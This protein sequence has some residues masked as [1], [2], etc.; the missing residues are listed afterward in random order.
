MAAGPYLRSF[1][2]IFVLVFVVTTAV[3]FL[4]SLIVHGSGQAEWGSAIRMG[5]ILGIILP[6][7]RKFES[8]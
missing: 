6:S 3:S 1:F 5:I 2:V 8:K 7:A 4:Y